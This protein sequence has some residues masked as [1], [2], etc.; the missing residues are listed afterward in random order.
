MRP[1]AEEIEVVRG[2]QPDGIRDEAAAAR[3]VRE[4][5]TRIA[6]R[7]DFLN[8]VI[9]FRLDVVW[10]RSVAARFANILAKPDARVLDLCC[11]TGD[12]TFAM[13]RRARRAGGTGGGARILGADF[14]HTMLV[15]ARGKAAASG[16]D[17]EFVEA[18]ALRLPLPDAS[19]DLVT[20]VFGFR[21]LANYARGLEEIH[22][23]LRPGG[24]VGILEFS[25]LRGVALGGLYRFYFKRILPAIGGALSGYRDPYAYLPASVDR[26][27]SADTLAALMQGSG[28]QDVG[29]ERWSFGIV[30]LFRARKD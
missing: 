26:F 25:D 30:S 28:F 19:V 11:G 7:Y 13:E 21:N 10:R 14:A 24:E 8:R 23:V 17:A 15:R 27:P 4:M 20:S 12:L 9:S 29:I 6:P 16:S 1:T 22:R 3:R 2:T 5:F 18:D